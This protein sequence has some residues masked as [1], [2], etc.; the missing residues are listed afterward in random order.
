[1]RK[2]IIHLWKSFRLSL[3]FLFIH[4]S[5]T[6]HFVIFRNMSLL[7]G[8]WLSIFV[9]FVG[10]NFLFFVMFCFSHWLQ[11]TDIVQVMIREFVDQK[12]LLKEVMEEVTLSHCKEK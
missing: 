11:L 12:G 6:T 5:Y 1:M 2:K 4:I 8:G 10:F 7:K 3:F 9:M